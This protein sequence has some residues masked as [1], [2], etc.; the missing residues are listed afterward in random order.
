MH[1]LAAILTSITWITNGEA[2]RILS[3]LIVAAF[4]PLFAAVITIILIPL[5]LK[6]EKRGVPLVSKTSL[7]VDTVSLC[8]TGEKRYRFSYL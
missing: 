4:S 5:L 6:R 7:A 1:T 8:I 2:F 3:P